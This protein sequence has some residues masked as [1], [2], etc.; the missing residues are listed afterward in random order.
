MGIIIN[1]TKKK[2]SVYQEIKRKEKGGKKTIP[3]DNI[4]DTSNT[5]CERHFPLNYE[6]VTVF[7]RKR[8]RDPPSIFTCVKPSLLPTV[9]PSPRP[10]YDK[11]SSSTRSIME[12]ELKFFLEKDRINS[13]ETLCEK[14]S[15]DKAMILDVENIVTYVINNS[16][17]IFQSTDIFERTAIPYYTLKINKDLSFES[18]HASINITVSSLSSNRIIYLDTYSELQEAIRHLRFMDMDHKKSILL[19]QFA[20]MSS[21]T[22]VGEKK[23]KP[24]VIVRAFEYFAV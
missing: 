22:Y 19:E 9:P 14:V 8:P 10:S 23:Y 11:V 3:R 21:V 1:K 20:S 7:G 16:Y 5:V 18:Y 6:T 2:Y 15:K 12:D 4:P 13:F 17:L 24:E